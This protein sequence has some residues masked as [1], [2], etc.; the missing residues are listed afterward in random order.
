MDESANA[1]QAHNDPVDP[2]SDDQEEV[3]DHD[4]DEENDSLSSYVAL[5]DGTIYEAAELDAIALLAYTWNDD[6]VPEVSAQLV[7]S[8]R[9]SLP[10]LSER[11]KDKEKG[12]SKGKGRYLVRPSHLS[13]ED[14]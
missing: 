3:P 2:R 8:E 1:S 14:R 13:L 7:G 9:T 11:T 12:K 10:F 6:L 4:D 5:D